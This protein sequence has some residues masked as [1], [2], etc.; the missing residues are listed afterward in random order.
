MI[1]LKT[2]AKYRQ[3]EELVGGCAKSQG[4]WSIIGFIDYANLLLKLEIP[5]SFCSFVI[6]KRHFKDKGGGLN[7]T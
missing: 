6:A 2:S 5:K 4:K 3:G 1:D 7:F